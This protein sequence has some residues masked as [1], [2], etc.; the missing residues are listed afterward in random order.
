MSNPRL[1]RASDPQSSH[2]ND[3]LVVIPVY[4]AAAQLEVLIPRVRQFVCDENLLCIDDGS[5][6]GSGKI[7]RQLAVPM[8]TLSENCGKGKALKVGFRHAMAGGYRSVLTLDADLQHLPE[9]IPNFFAHDNGK[10]LLIGTRTISPRAMPPH[11]WLSNTLT[12][13][14]LSGFAGRRVRDSQCGFRLIPVTLL[15]QLSL[16]AERFDLESELLF[17]AIKTD[18][19]IEEVPISTIYNGNGSSIHHLRDTSNFIRQIWKS[20]WR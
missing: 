7:L 8:L 19:D 16:E 1:N 15:T 4:N 18:I 17:Q 9:E 13:I 10:R 5:T 12:S 11:R 3:V 20:L 6:D 2:A 14:I